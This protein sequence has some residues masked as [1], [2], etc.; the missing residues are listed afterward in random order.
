MTNH[1]HHTYPSS[2]ITHTCAFTGIPTLLPILP[3]TPAYPQGAENGCSLPFSRKRE[4]TETFINSCHLY[5][6]AR[7]S[8][9]YNEQAKVYWILSFM[10][11]GTAQNWR[12]F[13]MSH[14]AHGRINYVTVE[15]FL[16]EIEKKF[17][18]MD[19]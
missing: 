7:P 16:T 5:M 1:T 19:K 10:Q 11:S 14:I 12:N 3:S 13:I 2:P 9:F 8:E 4:E 15:Q 17:G 18:D 6:S